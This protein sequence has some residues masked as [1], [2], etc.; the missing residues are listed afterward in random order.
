MKGNGCELREGFKPERRHLT[1]GSIEPPDVWAG[2][3]FLVRRR[4][5]VGFLPVTT[6]TDISGWPCRGVLFFTSSVSLD[7]SEKARLDVGKSQKGVATT[8]R[9]AV[10]VL[11][12]TEQSGHAA[13]VPCIPRGATPGT[14]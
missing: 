10:H 6:C 13:Q 9:L 5:P 3:H 1:F 11:G 8:R 14:A 12:D 2:I 7:G 4:L